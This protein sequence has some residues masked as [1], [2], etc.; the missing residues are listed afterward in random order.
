M[1]SLLDDGVRLSFGSD[2][3]VT[4]EVPLEGLSVAVHRQT[5][6]REPPNGWIPEERIT[7]EEALMAYTSGVAYQSFD[8]NTWGRLLPG[9]EA[10]LII[11][12][13]DPRT[14]DPHLVAKSAVQATYRRGV[15]I[16]GAG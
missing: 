2:W 5:P 15:R 7:I 1:R 12:D 6:D 3:P 4:S 11:L 9:M 8:E 14:L 16:F 10:N 13:D